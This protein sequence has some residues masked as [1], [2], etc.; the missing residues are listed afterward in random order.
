MKRNNYI[1][2]F[3]E[4]PK[5]KSWTS[6][7]VLAILTR[8]SGSAKSTK[9][10]LEW[11]RNEIVMHPE[12]NVVPSDMKMT[13]DPN[14]S[15][16]HTRP[17]PKTK[18]PTERVIPK[19][20]QK[21]LA[22]QKPLRPDVRHITEGKDSSKDVHPVVRVNWTESERGWGE[23]PDGYSFHLTKEDAEAYIKEYWDKMPKEV[24]DEYSK[25]GEPLLSQVNA[26]TFRKI[27]KSKN[28]VRFF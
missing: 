7:Q 24:P 20:Q 12:W 13:E 11:A 28:G 1:E 8:L 15:Y 25:P 17:F 5:D 19:S 26:K 21:R 4:Q 23:R 10:D 9:K 18:P 22:I 2:F 3:R 6:E 27:K 16:I 14:K